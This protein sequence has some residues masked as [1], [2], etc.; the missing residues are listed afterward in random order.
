MSKELEKGVTRINPKEV[1]QRSLESK[2]C[3]SLKQG[4]IKQN[5]KVFTV[6]VSL[7]Y[8]KRLKFQKKTFN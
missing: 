2:S 8:R 5:K 3:N 4:G 7:P 1:Q 6:Q